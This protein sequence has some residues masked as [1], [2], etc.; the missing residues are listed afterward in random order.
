M[1]FLMGWTLSQFAQAAAYYKRFDALPAKDF[2]G[3][4]KVYVKWRSD[5][6]NEPGDPVLIGVA[7]EHEWGWAAD[8]FNYVSISFKGGLYARTDDA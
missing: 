5:F 8:M 6:P 7:H 2:P 1:E 3:A 4:H